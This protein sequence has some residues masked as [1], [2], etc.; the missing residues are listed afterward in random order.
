MRKGS[1]ESWRDR[2]SCSHLRV[3]RLWS[4]RLHSRIYLISRCLHQ[5][6]PCKIRAI[7][8]TCGQKWKNRAVKSDYDFMIPDFNLCDFL[9][10]II[11]IA[12][13]CNMYVLQ[14][15]PNLVPATDSPSSPIDSTS[16]SQHCC[17]IPSNVG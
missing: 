17:W 6:A 16:A 11:S 15:N 8:S 3:R 13:S 10:L 12:P 9:I 1:E 2:S 14:R 7:S 5:C 4:E